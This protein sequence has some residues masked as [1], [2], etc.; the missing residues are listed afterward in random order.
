M[1]AINFSFLDYED[2]LLPLAKGD[3]GDEWDTELT[4]GVPDRR[5]SEESLAKCGQQSAAAMAELQ[6]AL[7]D[8]GARFTPE[9]VT[10]K[11]SFCWEH[12]G[13]HAGEV[14]AAILKRFCS[15][16]KY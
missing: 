15:S 13:P 14:R 7:H 8:P 16:S 10:R 12:S 6:R 3:A 2:E 4:D 5:H 9:E 1:S 11:F